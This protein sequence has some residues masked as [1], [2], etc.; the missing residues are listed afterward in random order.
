MKKLIIIILLYIVFNSIFLSFDFIYSQN[1]DTTNIFSSQAVENKDNNSMNVLTIIKLF[2]TKN[3]DLLEIIQI[4]INVIFLIIIAIF[5]ILAYRSA[6]KTIL[7]PMKSEI[8]QTIHNKLVDILYMFNNKNDY[9]LKNEMS[10]SDLIMI[11]N[12]KL[13]DMY[14]AFIFDNKFYKLMK[15]DN[16]IYNKAN[17]PTSKNFGN[18]ELTNNHII[19][20]E[21]C[22]EDNSPYYFEYN[23][24]MEERKKIWEDHFSNY[25]NLSIPQNYSS[26]EIKLNSIIS[27]PYTPDNIKNTIEEYKTLINS[28]LNIISEELK[29]F[30]QE[31]S[32]N[33]TLIDIFNTSI[34]YSNISNK[35]E[36]LENKASE[37]ISIINKII[38]KAFDIND[39]I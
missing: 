25:I 12:F 10:L 18:I 31:L 37:A 39:Y 24:S 7:D 29:Y 2:L 5:T 1:N 6:K 26:Y 9:D 19:L 13:K 35:L 38:K 3:K 33:D 11:N 28:N 34:S 23:L 32:K 21:L 20:I 4:I 14:A 8:L 15:F 27:S 30:A 36:S 17:C 22:L 16:L